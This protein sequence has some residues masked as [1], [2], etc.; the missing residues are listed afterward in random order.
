L[1]HFYKS[2]SEKVKKTK[3]V[4]KKSSTLGLQGTEQT[5]EH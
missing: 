5:G 4:I 1:I 3:N 2:F